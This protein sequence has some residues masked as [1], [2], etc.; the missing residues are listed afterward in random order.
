MTRRTGP[1]WQEPADPCED[2]VDGPAA[3]TSVRRSG[4]R[5]SG[6]Q[7]PRG[8]RAESRAVQPDGAGSRG[9]NP[10]G[11]NHPQGG[12]ARSRR[13]GAGVGQVVPEPVS[14]PGRRTTRK[15]DRPLVLNGRKRLVTALSGLAPHRRRRPRA[16]RRRP[17]PSPTS[18]TSR[19]R[20]DRLYHEA[21]QA[22]E[23]LQRRQARAR[24]PQRGDLASLKAD[25]APPGRPPRRR[26]GPGPR[27]RRPPVRGREH[28]R[29]RPA[30]SSP[31]TRGA[32]LSSSRPCRRS[33]TC[34]RSSST[35]TPPRSRRS[36]SARE[37]TAKRA[38]EV[39]ADRAAARG[40]EEDDRR[41]SSPRPR[42]CS[43]SSR[44]SE[45]AAARAACPHAA[46]R[47]RRQL[48]AGVRVAASGSAAAAVQLR[49]GPGRRRLRLRRRRPQRLRL[50]RPDDDGLGRGRR[51]RCRTPPAPSTAPARTSS[52]GDLQPGDLVFY[53]SPISH[54]GMY[55]GNGMIVH[56]ANPSTGCRGHRPAT[57]CR[58]SAR[59]ALADLPVLEGRSPTWWV[60]GLSLSPGPPG[61]PC[62]PGR[63]RRRPLR[64]AGPAGAP[65]AEARPGGR[66]RRWRRLER[67][68][69]QRTPRTRG[70]S[71]PGDAAGAACWRPSSPTPTRCDVA[72]LPA[73]LRRRA[74]ARSA[75]GRH[76]GRPRSTP[77]G[78]SA[79]S[80]GAPAH[81]EVAVTVRVRGR[82]GR[83]RR[84]RRA[85]TG[86][87]RCGS[88]GRCA[89]RAL[90]D[91]LVLVAGDAAAARRPA[92]YAAPAHRA[93]VPV[94]HRV[95]P[96]WR[97]AAG[98][99]GARR[100]AAG[101]DA[102]AGGRRRGST[103]ASPRSRRRV[104][105]SP[106]ERA[107][108]CTSS[109][110][111]EVFGGLQPDGRAGRD[112]PRGDPRGHRRGRSARCR[113]G[114]SRASPTTSRCATSTCR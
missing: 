52:E 18:T 31:T 16:R 46:P 26:A 5:G 23:R 83:D 94:V 86:G 82:P 2:L 1:C 51:L 90:P 21:E 33:T 12:G 25:Q 75:A 112:E 102:D 43:A 108:R 89:V 13:R 48:A 71:R 6:P 57:R 111:R 34:S 99:R 65:S 24:G 101:L 114:C 7:G 30:S 76:A 22:S 49:D 78:R 107:R 37:A 70:P 66:P 20:V 10:S 79:A 9:T 47:P 93:A 54:V 55:I 35:T 73:A 62:S 8:H 50:L 113:C 92:A 32:F 97:A 14:S 98:R 3:A 104:D 72:R 64:R 95:L 84:R 4:A 96:G 68:V 81:A 67:A 44:P 103:P 77:P 91:A 109:S 80:T 11:V 27:L 63:P 60:A 110:T 53:Y 100:T 61:R 106:G 45:R 39:A 28:L 105:G 36:T 40:R 87:R 88:P 17:R 42:R 38:A 56:A 41:P 85:A 69:D 19:S 15:G 74:R 59:S 29:G 58:T